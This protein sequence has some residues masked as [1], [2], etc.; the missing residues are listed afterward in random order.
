MSLLLDCVSVDGSAPLRVLVPSGGWAQVA[1][2]EPDALC[3]VI[4]GLRPGVGGII[5]DGR[6]LS[7]L[8]AAMRVRFGLATVPSRVPDLPGVSVLDV[9]L[10]ARPAGRD[11]R[12]WTTLLGVGR[13]RQQLGDA[14]AAVRSIAGRMGLAPWLDREAVRLPEEVQALLDAVRALSAAPDGLVW[15][16]PEWLPVAAGDELAQ[17]IVVEQERLGLTVVELTATATT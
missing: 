3:A 5:L 16:R 1:H 7:G 15:R 4:A 13:A 6:E 2:P 8:D 12:S 11:P 10:L 9:A 17:A 14:E